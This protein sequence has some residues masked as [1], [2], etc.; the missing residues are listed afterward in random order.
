MVEYTKINVKLSNSQLKKL[1]DAVSNNTGT[2]LT[3]NLK[4]FNGNNL[5]QEL[6]LTARQKTK[7]RNAFNNNTSTNMKLSKAQINKI[8]QSGGFLG[9]LL[10][11]LLKTGLTLIKNV[12][13]P[14]AK[15]VLIPLGLTAATSAADAG[16]HTKILGSG[17]TTLIISNEEMNDI[18][19]IVQALEDS[20]VLLKG[21]TETVKNETKEQKGWFLSMLLGTL[22]ASLLGNLLTGKGVVR[23]GY[24]NKNK[25]KGVVRAGYG[26]KNIGKGVVRAGYCNK[27]KVDF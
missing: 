26:N 8:I 7:I 19:K 24:G 15:S 6:L 2:T 22:G 21:V 25:G 14:L 20:N 17:N 1:K 16:I 12:I 13:K 9:K 18:I 11:P 3:I 27:N 5:P 4:M 23:A 10:G